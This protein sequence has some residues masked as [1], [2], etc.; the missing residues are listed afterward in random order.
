MRVYISG[1]M[2][3]IPNLNFEEFD[4]ARDMFLSLGHWVVSP[5]DLERC[6]GTLPYEESLKDDLK[7]LLWCDTIFLLKNWQ[8]SFGSKLEYQVAHALGYTKLY[9]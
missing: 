3:G 6:R 7:Y 9:E 8:R 4:K 2:T 1:P 5:A